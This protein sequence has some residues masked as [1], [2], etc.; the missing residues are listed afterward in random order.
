MCGGDKA[1][2]DRAEPVL[3]C[4]ARAVTLLGPV[5][6]GQLTKMVNQ[7]CIAGLVQGLSE[8]MHFGMKAGL[9]M[10]TV[11]DVISKCAAQYWKMEHPAK[12]AFEYKLEL[13]FDVARMRKD[14]G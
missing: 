14:H 5:G 3:D 2:F 12:N 13:A 8:G 1:V 7:I 4:Y 6:S 10:E 11:I 9:D